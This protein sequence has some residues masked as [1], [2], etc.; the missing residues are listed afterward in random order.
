MAED[1]AFADTALFVA[2]LL[3]ADRVWLT[4]AAVLG[5]ETRRMD[6]SICLPQSVRLMIQFEWEIATIQ[7]ADAVWVAE[8][9]RTLTRFYK[10]TEKILLV[11]MQYE[12][13]STWKRLQWD[14]TSSGEAFPH[15]YA[16][17]LTGDM[18]DVDVRFFYLF[19]RVHVLTIIEI[20]TQGVRFVDQPA[21]EK[22]WSAATE[23]LR[24]E[25]W[26]K[27]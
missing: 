7:N 4:D 26:L 6:L 25:G 10:D 21:S 12:R 14:P 9:P 23:A 20:L 17:A 22:G 27:E 3:V 1:F 24:T 19:L 16:T 5:A 13:L 2:V 8:L 11:R 18:V 15:L